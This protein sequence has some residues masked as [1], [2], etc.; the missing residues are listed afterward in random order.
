MQATGVVKPPVYVE[1]SRCGNCEELAI[2]L[3]VSGKSTSRPRC[4]CGNRDLKSI[5]KST[6]SVVD[7]RATV[8]EWE[9]AD[10]ET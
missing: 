7:L 10:K 5:G 3:L 4:G 6:V 9:G 1:I 2:E 8:A